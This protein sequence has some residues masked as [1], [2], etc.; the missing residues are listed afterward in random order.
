MK[1]ALNQLAYAVL[2]KNSLQEYNLGELKQL[3][4]RHPYS[5]ALQLLLAAKLQAEE[6]MEF[7]SQLQITALHIPEAARL[8]HILTQKGSVQVES[9]KKEEQATS[10]LISI[11]EPVTTTEPIKEFINENPTLPAPEQGKKEEFSFGLELTPVETPMPEEPFKEL[12]SDNPPIPVWEP[13][14]KEEFSFNM[15]IPPVETPISAEPFKELISD[16]PPIPVWEPEKAEEP[17]L[18]PV[19]PPNYHNLPGQSE[20]KLGADTPSFKNLEPGKLEQHV[21]PSEMEILEPGVNDTEN[22][23]PGH[24]M[25][26]LEIPV[27]KMEQIDPQTAE[28][29]FEPYHTVD[30][31]ASQGIRFREE[32]KPRDKFGQQLK[33]FTEWLKLLKTAPVAETAVGS[34][35]AAEEKVEQL[36]AHSLADREVVTEAMAEVW[37]KQGKHDKALAIYHKLSLLNPSKS[38]YFAAK[39]DQLKQT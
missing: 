29:S 25:P 9:K 39:I 2:Q 8:E 38:S 16:N 23:E 35:P 20:N 26:V 32:E 7:P 30:Y 6:D 33:S 18:N 28:I 5:S 37:E 19:M 21:L 24:D 11:P 15:E 10:Q 4:N 3:A 17:F 14:K 27:L 22:D 12:I 36:A 34:T 31:F 13:E 1:N